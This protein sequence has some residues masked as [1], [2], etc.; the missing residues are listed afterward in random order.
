MVPLI[1]LVIIDRTMK[2]RTQGLST[3]EEEQQQTNQIQALYLVTFS[4]DQIIKNPNNGAKLLVTWLRITKLVSPNLLSNDNL[5][6]NG[7]GAGTTKTE[8]QPD[9]FPYW[10]P[11]HF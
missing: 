6:P 4:I 11:T 1:R 10:R 8:Q 2:N 9:F 3:L 7:R 5:L